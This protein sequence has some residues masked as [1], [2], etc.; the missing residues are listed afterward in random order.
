MGHIPAHLSNHSVHT[1]TDG[2]TNL[3][4]T[5]ALGRLIR[6]EE[7]AAVGRVVSSELFTYHSCDFSPQAL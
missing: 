1:N 7:Q 5:H 3:L 6:P 2:A 4:A